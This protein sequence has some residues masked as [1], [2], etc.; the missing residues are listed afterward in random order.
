MTEALY[1]ILSMPKMG[2]PKD[3]SKYPFPAS[4]SQFSS[5]ANVE[6]Y[7]MTIY[8]LQYFVL[9]TFQMR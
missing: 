8:P 3:T 2:K 6:A 9:P 7:L 1:M 5:I 4:P